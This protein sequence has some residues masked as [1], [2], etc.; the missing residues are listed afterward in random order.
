MK[1]KAQINTTS[2]HVADLKVALREDMQILLLITL[3]T[4]A[5]SDC[6]QSVYNKYI[7]RVYNLKIYAV[8]STNPSAKENY[9]WEIFDSQRV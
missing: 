7:K 2:F 6:L 4:V 3:Q 8:N 1:G 9:I 5:G